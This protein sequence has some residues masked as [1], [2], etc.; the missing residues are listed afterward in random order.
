M[1]AFVSPA[2]SGALYV[3]VALI[4]L[5][6]DTRLERAAAGHGPS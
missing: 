5:V 1:A 2:V 4:W 3:L 6:P